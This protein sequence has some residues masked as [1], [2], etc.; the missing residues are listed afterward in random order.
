MP[1]AFVSMILGAGQVLPPEALQERIFHNAVESPVIGGDFTVDQ[2]ERE[3]V[4]RVL[5]RSRTQE[6][7]AHILGVDG[8]TLWRKRRRYEGG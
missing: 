7:E 6:E 8:S 1:G 4:L 3:H 5:A 2:V